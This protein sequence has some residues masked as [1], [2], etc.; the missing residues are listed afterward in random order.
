MG[1]V[2]NSRKDTSN[3]FNL[4]ITINVH[5]KH[6][7]DCLVLLTLQTKKGEQFWDDCIAWD[8]P[9]NL[10]DTVLVFEKN[11]SWFTDN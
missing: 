10:L 4:I 5:H 8:L 1:P 3:V 11:L 7:S 2:S 6:C 9:R